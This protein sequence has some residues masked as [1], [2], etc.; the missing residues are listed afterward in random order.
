MVTLTR[1]FV[2]AA[3]IASLLSVGACTDTTAPATPGIDERATRVDV[4]PPVPLPP[5]PKP[6]ARARAT[7]P[8]VAKQTTPAKPSSNGEAVAEAASPPPAP[9]GTAEPP[10][11][12]DKEETE[13]PQNITTAALSPPTIRWIGLDRNGVTAMLGVPIAERQIAAARVWD[14][15]ATD[16]RLAVFFYLDTGRNDFYALHYEI[17]GATPG[18]LSSEQCLQRIRD[19]ARPR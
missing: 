19:N 16:C 3:V 5:P 12:K 18:S 14:Y 1:T 17:D 13:A 9:S 15:R 7:T 10:P 4:P 2:G 8:A 11:S 6:Q